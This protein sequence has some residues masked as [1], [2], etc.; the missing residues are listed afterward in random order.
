M[1]SLKSGYTFH[2]LLDIRDDEEKLK[3]LSNSPQM[4]QTREELAPL[5]SFSV[6]KY[7]LVYRLIPEGIDSCSVGWVL[8]FSVRILEIT[9]I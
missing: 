5:R 8:R 9:Q 7:L 4:G 1:T 2:R 3:L 6:G